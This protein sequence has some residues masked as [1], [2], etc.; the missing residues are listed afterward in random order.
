MI[1]HL[2]IVAVL[3]ALPV[4]GAAPPAAQ[5]DAVATLVARL[6]PLREFQPIVEHAAGWR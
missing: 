1:R 2:G 5:A 4:Q 6:D 3:L